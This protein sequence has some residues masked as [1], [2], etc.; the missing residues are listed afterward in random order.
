[1]NGVVMHR[2]I[3]GAKSVHLVHGLPYHSAA[4]ILPMEVRRLLRFFKVK[5]LFDISLHPVPYFAN[6][7]VS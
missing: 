6:S 7:V 5:R 2:L 3:A 4:A 1:M